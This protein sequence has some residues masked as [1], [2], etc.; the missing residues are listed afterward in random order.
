M[1]TTT[2]V[3][4]RHSDP[5]GVS[6]TGVVAEGIEFSD[7]SVAL[8]WTG[9]T[10]STA[11][12]SDIR[13]VERIHG[14]QGATVVEFTE[15]ER[16]VKAYQQFVSKLL[17]W[18]PLSGPSTCGPHPDHPDRLRVTFMQ[19]WV[20]REWVQMLGGSTDAAVH[21]PTGGGET[22]HRWVSPDGLLWLSYF[23][24]D[25]PAGMAWERHDDPEVDL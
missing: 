3:L 15:A 22:E 16:L 19:E 10:P 8:R 17:L 5:S 14:H 9:D 13:H 18:S 7:G 24:T 25:A 6:G 21:E 11:V 12:W 4:Q 1:T 20:W 2:F 23:T